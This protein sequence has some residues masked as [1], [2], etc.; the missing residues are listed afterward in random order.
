VFFALTDLLRIC[1]KTVLPASFMYVVMSLSVAIDVV[2]QTVAK[3]LFPDIYTKVPA[4]LGFI[5]MALVG[6]TLVSVGAKLWPHEK[7]EP[8]SVV[9]E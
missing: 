7:S 4:T 6:G 3:W 5:L 2:T 9:K 8:P 1:V